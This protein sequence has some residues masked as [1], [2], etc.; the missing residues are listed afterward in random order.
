MKPIIEKE[1]KDVI[2]IEDITREHI[3]VSV[4]NNRPSIVTCE[5]Y[6]DEKYRIRPI[7][8][9]FIIGNGF[10]FHGSIK[11]KIM[12]AMKENYPIAVF[13]QSNWKQALQW[14]IDNA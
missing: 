5:A 1:Q 10:G 14:L 2:C 12:E 6:N 7:S 9:S 8:D 13:H 4:Y 3:V 11:E